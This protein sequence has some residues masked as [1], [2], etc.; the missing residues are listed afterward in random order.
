MIDEAVCREMPRLQQA[1]KNLLVQAKEILSGT[2]IN[3]N[4]CC[5]TGMRIDASRPIDLFST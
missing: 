2:V 4:A 3:F 1:S 5:R